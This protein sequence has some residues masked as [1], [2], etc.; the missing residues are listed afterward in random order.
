MPQ[1][2]A[3]TYRRPRAIENFLDMGHFPSCIPA[4]SGEEPFTEV[5]DYDVEI[6]DDQREIL[7][8]TL[9]LLSAA[10]VADGD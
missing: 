1:P 2:S 6:V 4:I 5:K 8:H 3:C 9:P 7:G 10:A